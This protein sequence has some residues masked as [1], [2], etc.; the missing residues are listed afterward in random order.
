MPTIPLSGLMIDVFHN[1][2][3][4]N[5]PDTVSGYMS[6]SMVQGCM[7]YAM[8]D[9]YGHQPYPD[10]ITKSAAL[11]YAIITFHPFIDGNKRTALLS[12]FFMLYFN[13]YFF[14]ITEEAVQFTKQI[15]ERK[16]Q[17]VEIVAQWLSAHARKNWFGSLMSRFIISRMKERE[18]TVFCITMLRQISVL[19]EPFERH[20][21]TKK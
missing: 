17:K 14:A 10:V 6:E 7:D 21:R 15:A 5:Y 9:V 1:A 20:Y 19:L 13:G 3:L 18:R 16:I 2:I 12:T 4:Q 8:T 11:M